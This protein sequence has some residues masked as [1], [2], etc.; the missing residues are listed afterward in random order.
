MQMTKNFFKMTIMWSTGSFSIYLLN[1]LNKYLEG[2][3][4]Q[5]H[6]SEGVAGLAAGLVG[7]KIYEKMGKKFSFVFSYSLALT[8]GI[9]IY[10]LE[11]GH[12]YLPNSFIGQFDGNVRH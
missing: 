4:Y 5:N 8:G 1:F 3:I 11:S 9:L 2:T 12:F 7:A 6:Y 10:L